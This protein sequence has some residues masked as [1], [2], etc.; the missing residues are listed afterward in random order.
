MN[1][2][3]Y[4]INQFYPDDPERNTEEIMTGDDV[5]TRFPHLAHYLN[6]PD[7]HSIRLIVG[8]WELAISLDWEDQPEPAET[9]DQI[10][11]CQEG[12]LGMWG[13]PDA[14]WYWL[15]GDT[16]EPQ[17]YGPFKTEGAAYAF[18]SGKLDEQKQREDNP[19]ELDE[20]TF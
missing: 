10:K 6:D 14:G 19:I 2:N 18:R 1:N 17:P 3:L 9:V 15:S 13:S 8:L 16:N 7:F 5:A 20:I 4:A 11:Y 12:E